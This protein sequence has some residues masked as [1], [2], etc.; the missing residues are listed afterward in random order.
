MEEIPK[1]ITPYPYNHK[2]HVKNS[3]LDM[4]KTWYFEAYPKAQES[5]YERYRDTE[6]C[7]ICSVKM[8]DCKSSPPTRKTQDTHNGIPFGVICYRC[9]NV[10]GSVLDIEHLTQLK[11]YLKERGI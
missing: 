2:N 6:R 5:H 3:K 9:A 11:D 7:D 4:Q 10:L 1:G 8:C